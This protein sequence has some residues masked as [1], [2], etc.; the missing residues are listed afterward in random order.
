MGWQFGMVGC[1]VSAAI[2]PPVPPPK[3]REPRWNSV[4]VKKTLYFS[5]LWISVAFSGAHWKIAGG[6]V[7]AILEE[8]GR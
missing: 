8:S 3:I 4:D 7:F 1:M 5:G 6:V 2:P